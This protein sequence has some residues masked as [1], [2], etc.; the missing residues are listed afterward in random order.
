MQ[1]L[2]E[3]ILR[4]SA[5][6]LPIQEKRR[7]L[8]RDSD[9]TFYSTHRLFFFLGLKPKKSEGVITRPGFSKIWTKEEKEKLWMFRVIRALINKGY[10]YGFSLSKYED[11][12]TSHEGISI[13]YAIQA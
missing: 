2:N 7:I 4:Y 5:Y 12:E 8:L 13:R 9:A 1:T 3:R 11:E 10:L 6:D